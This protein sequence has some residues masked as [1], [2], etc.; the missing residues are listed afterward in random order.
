MHAATALNELLAQHAKLREMMDRADELADEVDRGGD[1][2]LLTHAVARI[3]IAFDAHNT[4]EEHLLRPVLESADSFG[5]IRIEHM[6]TDHICEHRAM[7]KDL[8]TWTVTAVLREA[9]AGLRAHLD[10]E[11]RYFLTA[12]VLRDD[13]VES[14]G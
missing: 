14:A 4:Y 5:P 11:E 9:L 6:V 12:R 7:R 10:A 8:A 1:P 13:L 3:R 2:S